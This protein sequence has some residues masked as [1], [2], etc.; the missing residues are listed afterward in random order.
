MESQ[1]RAL[2]DDLE[3][4]RSQMVIRNLDRRG[5]PKPSCQ[6]GIVI[7][8]AA[9]FHTDLQGK[10]ADSRSLSAAALAGWVRCLTMVSSSIPETLDHKP[11]HE[12]C[13]RREASECPACL[14]LDR[15][16]RRDLI[17]V[18]RAH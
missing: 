13:L 15:N 2:Q 7:R 3:G 14:Q 6:S 4:Y 12:D 18:L 1:S 5:Y 11:I 10:N 16:R 17:L 8:K 9:G